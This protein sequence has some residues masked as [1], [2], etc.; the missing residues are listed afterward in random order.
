MTLVRHS[1]AHVARTVVP[2]EASEQSAYH[3]VSRGLRNPRRLRDA[4]L[5]ILL[6]TLTIVLHTDGLS[7]RHQTE[8]DLAFVVTDPTADGYRQGPDRYSS[9][10]PSTG[11]TL[12]ARSAGNNG[13]ASARVRHVTV[14]ISSVP[15][16]PGA[17]P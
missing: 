4:L 12:E 7:R 10:S 3:R 14:A 8:T 9:R 2:V 1:T 6:L 13:A 17:M 15:G 5:R 11:A 16:T